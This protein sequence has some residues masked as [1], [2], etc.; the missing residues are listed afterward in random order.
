VNR[1]AIAID[2]G[3]GTADIVVRRDGQ[4][5]E[6]SVK[7]VV[8]SRTRIVAARIAAATRGGSAVLFQGPTMGGGAD[9]RAMKAHT[10]AGL[11]F[12]ATAAAAHS[13]ADDLER[14]RA[15][16]VTIVAD[17]EAAGLAARGSL[18]AGAG[19][20][21][22]VVIP[23]GDVDA[24]S[25]LDALERL[26]VD[27]RFDAAAVGVQDHGFCPGGSNR[28]FRFELWERAVRER[29]ALPELFYWSPVHTGR[30]EAGPGRDE[31]RPTRDEAG[32]GR[33]EAG[34]A[35]DAAGP[36]GPD[37]SIP[38]ALT[39]MRAAARCIAPLVAGARRGPDG[40]VSDAEVGGPG[41]GVLAGDT[42]PA[43]LLGAL[44]D[45]P[46]TAEATVL[47]NVG[48]GHTIAAV[49]RDG[50]L[51][52]VYEHHTGLLDGA[53]LEGQVRRFLRGELSADEVRADG[54]HGAV[55]DGPVALTAPLLVTGPNR[56]LLRGTSFDV[57]YPAP[58]GDMMIAGSVGLL[59]ALAHAE[60]R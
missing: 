53:R 32:P 43:A 16:G 46:Q 51:A 45:A 25:L 47:V 50:R 38:P 23:S 10:A 27:T 6:N 60:P 56:G 7:L 28:V 3:A 31:D 49:A 39:R 12:L 55:I 20:L 52:G 21:E 41:A 40:P 17:D 9:T 57:R 4:P 14:V 29:R 26:G 24:V 11:P 33:D 44:T 54:G 30:D 37:A 59:E 19:R 34:A 22:L 35:W 58:W 2:V 15:R 18:R 42:G 5:P 8:P 13:F 1:P 36:G 48:N